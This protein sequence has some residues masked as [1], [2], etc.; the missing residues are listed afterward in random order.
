ME[1]RSSSRCPQDVLVGDEEL[2]WSC[3]QHFV[4]RHLG[5]DVYPSR[6]YEAACEGPSCW[7]G[8][9]NCTPVHYT[10]HVL[11]VCPRGCNDHRVPH[12][13]RPLWHWTE[14]NVTVGCQCV[15]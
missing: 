10:L 2:P 1:Q 4:W 12:A 7:Y 14:M 3:R 5:E 8:H 11:Q 6:V 9:F 15:R 13:L